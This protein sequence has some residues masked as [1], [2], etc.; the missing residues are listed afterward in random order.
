M[1][2]MSERHLCDRDL[3]VAPTGNAEAVE[4]GARRVGA[5]EGVE[6]DSGDVV[7]QEVV[8]LF[9]GEVDADAADHLAIV[10]ATLE[11]AQ[12]LGGK[13]GAA[14]ELGDAFEAAHGGDRHDAGDDRDV[15]AGERTTFAEIEEVAIIEEELGDDVVGAGVD[16]RF[17]VIHFDQSIRRRRMAFRETGHTDPETAAIGMRAGFVEFA[18]ELHQIDRVL[19][20]VGGFVVDASV[21]RIAT[22]GENISDAGLGVAPQNRFDLA[23]LVAD[24]SEVRDRVEFR[25]GLNA[26]DEVVREIARGATGAVGDTDEVRHVCFQFA[27][28][29]VEGLGRFRRFRR[30]EL[31]RKRRGIPLHD[32]GDVHC[33]GRIFARATTFGQLAVRS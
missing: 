24:A 31:E 33:P 19:E 11:G 18:N 29:L 13:A 7:V 23:V 27:N 17:E 10:V 30:K 26:L 14:G 21:G 5:V 16:L 22:Q 32:V 8:A 25:S 12:K 1:L 6:M 4:D 15:D 2:K 3:G 20:D 9:Q 28:G